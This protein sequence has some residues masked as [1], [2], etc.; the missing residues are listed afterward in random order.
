MFDEHSRVTLVV[1]NRSRRPRSL[2]KDGIPRT[3]RSSAQ[4]EQQERSPTKNAEYVAE[5]EKELAQLRVAMAAQ[6]REFDENATSFSQ[7]LTRISH[8]ERTLSLT[9]TKLLA[10]EEAAEQTTTLRTRVLEL[11]SKQ[12]ELREHA[13]AQLEACTSE[14]V[15]VREALAAALEREPA[16]RRTEAELRQQLEASVQRAEEM[17][18]LAESLSRDSAAGA[19][20]CARL[21]ESHKLIEE[22]ESQALAKAQAVGDELAAALTELAGVEL[23]RTELS[24]M[25]AKQR[26]DLEAA[27]RAAHAASEDRRQLLE[28]LNVVESMAH[29]IA[30]TAARGDDTGRTE[31][32][33][34]DDR[35]TFRP[36]PARASVAP[37][38]LRRSTAPEI[39]IDGVLLAP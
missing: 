17:R 9:K 19:D 30:R 2:S 31:S 34:E 15:Q 24:E 26:G 29:R 36:G 10:A 1:M 7:A 39:L 35:S 3:R 37:R 12:A 13:A 32:V 25:V 5:L 18:A 23:E 6:K 33:T 16:F 28:L 11:E 20:E 14:A 8:S 4:S 22:R 38:A 21:A 27:S